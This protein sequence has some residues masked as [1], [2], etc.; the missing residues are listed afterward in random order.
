MDSLDGYLFG[1]GYDYHYAINA[2]FTIESA[3][4]I[5]YE[6]NAITDSYAGTH[7]LYVSHDNGETWTET[8]SYL[9]VVV[10]SDTTNPDVTDPP[11]DEIVEIY[12]VEQLAEAFTNGGSYKLM[13]NLDVVDMYIGTEEVVVLNLDLGGYT[14]TTNRGIGI[15]IGSTV[16]LSNG[17]IQQV[18]DS[19]A[20]IT[21]YG[22]VNISNC[23]LIGCDYYGL[24]VMDDIVTV[25]NSVLIGGVC[26]TTGYTDTASLIATNNVTITKIE[27]SYIGGIA[28]SS[29]ADALFNFDPTDLFCTYNNGTVVNNGNGTWSVISSK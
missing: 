7:V 15:W 8:G 29:G 6:E 27:G 10:P 28:V 26:V 21:S 5:K 11:A 4:A 3:A 14:I 9:T 1:I 20:A 17:T 24:Y 18:S 2:A 13:N 19:N 22:I 25:E 12:T 16:N 23:T